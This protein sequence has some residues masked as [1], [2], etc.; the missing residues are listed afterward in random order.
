[1][2]SRWF[3]V[4]R[5]EM[6]ASSTGPTADLEVTVTLSPIIGPHRAARAGFDEGKNT[7]IRKNAPASS[8]SKRVWRFAPKFDERGLITA[9]TTDAKSGELLMQGYMNAEALALTITSGEAHYYS[10]SPPDLYGTK[11]QR[12]AWCNVSYN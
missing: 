10:R 4:N 7:A 8:W 12:A 5:L 6:I 3:V 1:M 9:V 11:V 2:S